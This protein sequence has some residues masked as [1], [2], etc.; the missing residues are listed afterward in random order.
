MQEQLTDQ[1]IVIGIKEVPLNELD[2]SP[3]NGRARTHIM[4]SHTAKGGCTS[5]CPFP[6]YFSV[7]I[8]MFDFDAYHAFISRR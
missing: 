3:V 7:K 5:L 1:S 2:T 6:P 8:L 4:F